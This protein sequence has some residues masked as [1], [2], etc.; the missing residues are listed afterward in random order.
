MSDDSTVTS[1][2]KATIEPPEAMAS[3][4]GTWRIVISGLEAPEGGVVRVLLSGSRGNPSD[5][6]RPQATEPAAREYV[7]AA[8]TGSASLTV[9]IPPPEPTR[10]A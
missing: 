9:S 4:P 2:V 3:V 5:W 6:A 10:G 8:S 7:T 1:D